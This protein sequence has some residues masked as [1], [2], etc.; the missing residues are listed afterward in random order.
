M[1]FQDLFH[2]PRRGAFHLS[3][4]V[5]VHYRSCR[6]FSLGRWSPP[7]PTAYHVGGRTQVAIGSATAFGYGALTPSG[8]PFQDRSPSPRVAHSPAGE[9]PRLIAPP[10]PAPQ[11]RSPCHDAGLGCPRFV[12]HYYGDTLSSSGYV[13]CFSWPGTPPTPI[14]SAPGDALARAGLPHSDTLGSQPASGSP[15]PCAAWPRPSSARHA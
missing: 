14:H 6:V 7:L 11:R 9:P 5:L 10:T 8:R 3:L 2:P 1:G 12:R 15:R 13:R 4:T